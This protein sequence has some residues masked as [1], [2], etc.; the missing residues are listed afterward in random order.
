M[1]CTKY[2]VPSYF[3]NGTTEYLSFDLNNRKNFGFNINKLT[4]FNCSFI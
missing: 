2:I 1:L 4:T 3:K